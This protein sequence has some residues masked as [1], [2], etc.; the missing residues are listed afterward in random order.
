[1]YDAPPRKVS[2]MVGSVLT[3]NPRILFMAANLVIVSMIFDEGAASS[4]L[5]RSGLGGLLVSDPVACAGQGDRNPLPH[6]NVLGGCCDPSEAFA[7]AAC[8]LLGGG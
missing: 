2:I 5:R 6:H 8:G 4:S 1:M 7:R 3:R